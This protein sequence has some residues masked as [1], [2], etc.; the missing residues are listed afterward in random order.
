MSATVSLAMILKV[1]CLPDV[2]IFM[3]IKYV[4]SKFISYDELLLL[5][6]IL[7]DYLSNYYYNN[8]VYIELHTLRCSQS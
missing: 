4:I 7:H 6:L 2:Y 3:K 1:L 5:E 8:N